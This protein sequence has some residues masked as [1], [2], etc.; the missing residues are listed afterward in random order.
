MCI[1]CMCMLCMC[2]MGGMC[3][4]Y[5]FL[6]CCVCVCVH[7]Y[8]CSCESA[9][10][11]MWRP[12]V[13][14]LKLL[15]TFDRLGHNLHSS[16]WGISCLYL[17]NAGVTGIMIPDYFKYGLWELKLTSSC[18]GGNLAISLVHTML[19]FYHL[20]KRYLFCHF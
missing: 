9:C 17:P 8:F 5:T 11:Y 6:V 13:N 3:V 4:I 18:L 14:V 2:C 15:F 10:T 20:P 7:V 12:V 1:L 19:S 16:S